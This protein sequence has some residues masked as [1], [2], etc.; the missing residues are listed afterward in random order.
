MTK[1][2]HTPGPWSWITVCDELV[3]IEGGS[4]H[5]VLTIDVDRH[6]CGSISIAPDD[7]NILIAA[8]DMYEAALPFE[9]LIKIILNDIG[10]KERDPLVAYA[11]NGK[12]AR[13]TPAQGRAFLAALAKARGEKEQ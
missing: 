8:P 4:G 13:I 9:E 3:M 2:K 6:G 5:S 7:A 10:V 11:Y 1:P 12:G